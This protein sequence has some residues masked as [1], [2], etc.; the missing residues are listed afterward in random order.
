MV[1]IT[2]ELV[3]VYHGFVSD[4]KPTTPEAR[5][6]QLE[7]NQKRDAWLK[8]EAAKQGIE[9]V[10]TLQKALAK[11]LQKKL[12]KAKKGDKKSNPNQNKNKK[13]D[14]SKN[15]EQQEKQASQEVKRNVFETLSKILEEPSKNHGRCAFYVNSPEILD[16]HLN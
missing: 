7:L 14:N 12:K 13:V 2:D 8:E 1:S 3:Q 6:A 5:A 11:A 10:G 15:V 9:N 4:E 16:K